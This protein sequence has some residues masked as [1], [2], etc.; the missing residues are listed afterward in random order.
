MRMTQILYA[1]VVILLPPTGALKRDPVQP[2]RKPKR[3]V[4]AEIQAE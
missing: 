1:A 3:I 4:P 2:G